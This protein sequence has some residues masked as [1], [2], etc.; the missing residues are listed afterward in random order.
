LAVAIPAGAVLALKRGAAFGLNN[1]TSSRII[2][3]TIADNE[4][5]TA[6]GIND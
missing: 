4:W 5:L 6:V 2:N 3:S 1:R